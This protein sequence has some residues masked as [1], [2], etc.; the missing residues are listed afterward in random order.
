MQYERTLHASSLE[1][2]DDDDNEDRLFCRG[3]FMVQIYCVRTYVSNNI[4]DTHLLN[5]NSGSHALAILSAHANQS[6]CRSQAKTTCNE[7]DLLLLISAQIRREL[8]LVLDGVNTL[9]KWGNVDT[10]RCYHEVSDNYC[11]LRP[12]RISIVVLNTNQLFRSPHCW[13]KNML[14]QRT[15]LQWFT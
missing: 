4:H 9:P 5:L 10:T 11:W 6:E 7:L 8:S 14:T 1:T 13:R 2:C 15:S 3:I 12:H